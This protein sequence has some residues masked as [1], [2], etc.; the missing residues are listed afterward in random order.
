MIDGYLD[1]LIVIVTSLVLQVCLLLNFVVLFAVRCI[2]VT[3]RN[4]RL[5]NTQHI[6]NCHAFSV[7]KI[8]LKEAA[9]T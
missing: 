9:I 7:D 1:L 6:K 4:V 3:D 2:I 8:M 5:K